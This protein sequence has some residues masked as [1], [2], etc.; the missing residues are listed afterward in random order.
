MR[1]T[2]HRLRR[3]EQRLMPKADPSASRAVEL[4]RERR[5]R[6]MEADGRPHEDRPLST[7]P[8]PTGRPL[9]IAEVLRQRPRTWTATLPP[10]S[11]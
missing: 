3:L 9:S 7:I 10:E 11:E 5:R 4:L 1:I 2:I 6:Q 8:L